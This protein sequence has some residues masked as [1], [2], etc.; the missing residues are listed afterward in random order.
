MNERERIERHMST[1]PRL[2]R[3]PGWKVRDLTEAI[4]PNGVARGYLASDGLLV[5]IS[6]ELDVFSGRGT[7]DWLHASFSRK[8]RIP[9]YSDMRRVKGAVFGPN[10]MAVQVFPKQSDH[11]SLHQ[12]C[13]HLWGCL[14]DEHY[15]PD[16]LSHKGGQI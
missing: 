1:V 4:D 10:R 11:Y 5:L 7:N 16:F 9:T 15:L 13:L 14:T 12:Y 6:I 2:E 8:D 3:A